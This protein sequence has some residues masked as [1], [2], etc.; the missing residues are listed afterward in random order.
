MVR[1]MPRSVGL[2]ALRVGRRLV[3]GHLVVVADRGGAA[4]DGAG[5]AAAVGE[6]G[7]VGGDD[8]L[9]RRQG[10]APLARHQAAKSRQSAA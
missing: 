5:L 10:V 6:A 9:V 7:E 2:H 4:A 3:A 8:A 1:R